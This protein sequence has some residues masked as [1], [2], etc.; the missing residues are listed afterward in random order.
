MAPAMR[1]LATTLVTIVAIASTTVSA[2]NEAYPRGRVIGS[3]EI[4]ALHD[5]VN[6]DLHGQPTPL[7]LVTLY[8]EPTEHTAVAAVVS[9]RTELTSLEHGY[10]QLSAAV[11]EMREIDDRVWYRVHYTTARSFGDAWIS[12][13]DTST[14][15]PLADV[16]VHGLAFLTDSWD[17]AVFDEP[18]AH[19]GKRTI[20][21]TIERPNV[22]VLATAG[23]AQHLWLRIELLD[24]GACEGSEQPA[25]A[26]SGWIPAFSPDGQLT[27]WHYPRG[28]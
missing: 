2:Q 3:I 14:Y 23:D 21:V 24:G 13:R 20:P 7:S 27:A 4:P 15:H 1:L 22:H 25:I 9:D 28:C 17:R 26:T 16:L 19:S 6:R 8:I 18:G 10:E 11:Y 5:A 12:S